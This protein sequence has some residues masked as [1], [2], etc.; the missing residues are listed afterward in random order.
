M[1]ENV[2]KGTT[3][4]FLGSTSER[5]KAK[6]SHWVAFLSRKSPMVGR[7]FWTNDRECQKVSSKGTG[8]CPTDVWWVPDRSNWGRSHF[9][10]KAID[11][12][13]QH[14][15]RGRRITTLRELQD[16]DKEEE[17]NIQWTLIG[18]YKQRNP[19][20]VPGRKRHVQ[21]I[22][23]SLRQIAMELTKTK[24]TIDILSTIT[25]ISV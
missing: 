10:F 1:P 5:W 20:T 24:Y 16:N 17:S 3:Q 13:L 23:S 11:V 15:H 18:L 7:I 2:R 22:S 21:H 9:K 14:R 6:P 8:K 4:T 25:E 12:R 19:L